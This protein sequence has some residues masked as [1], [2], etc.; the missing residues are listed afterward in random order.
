MIFKKMKYKNNSDA[1]FSNLTS[2]NIPSANNNNNDSNAIS[3]E[4]SSRKMKNTNASEIEINRSHSMRE[5]KDF[6]M[7]D[8][9]LN[10]IIPEEESI[11][12]IKIYYHLNKP[13]D[14]FFIFLGIIGSLGAGVSS[15]LM[16]FT[17]SEVYSRIANTSENRDS[18]FNLEE[19]EDNV[20]KIMDYKIKSLLIYGAISF[21]CYFMSIC[22]WSLVGNRCVYNLKKNYFTI[23][24]KQEQAWF[25]ANNPF[26][27]GSSVNAQLTNIEQGI[28]DKVGVLITLFAQCIVGFILSFISTWKLT[29]VMLS[30]TPLSIIFPN[31]L[32]MSM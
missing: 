15:P 20:K 2:N 17:T 9:I 6:I 4:F 21:L 14:W 8:N 12:L 16:S 19:M 29:L 1:L 28:G 22:C 26:E 7:K 5:S 3:V 13:I 32:I 23:I 11:N 10:K 18:K 24:L 27:L 25:D 30:V 31:F